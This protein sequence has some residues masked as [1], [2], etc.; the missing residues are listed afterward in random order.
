MKHLIFKKLEDGTFAEKLGSYEG[1]K[2]DSSANRSYLMAE[3]MA[4]HFLLPEGADEDCCV[5][6]LVEEQIIPAQGVE[7]E[8]EGEEGYVAEQ[9]IPAHYAVQEDAG[10][11]AAKASAAI[12]SN[13]QSALSSAKAFGE[14]LMSEFTVENIMLGITADNMTGTVRKNMAEVIMALQTGSLYDAIV[15][16]K[17]IPAEDKDAKY[18]TD[19]RLLSFVNKIETKLGI[20]LSVSL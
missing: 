3:P 15:E 19:A 18:I 1:P 10:L 8:G 12:L 13:V 11:V 17:A 5:L 7:G 14:A 2:D 9:I 16:A 6:V 20:T 4:S